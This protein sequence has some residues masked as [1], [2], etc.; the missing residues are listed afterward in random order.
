MSDNFDL[1]KPLLGDDYD[2]DFK[3]KHYVA[4]RAHL[5]PADIKE[6]KSVKINKLVH[7]LSALTDDNEFDKSIKFTPDTYWYLNIW[8]ENMD[9]SDSGDPLYV[10]DNTWSQ[11]D[12]KQLKRADPK[13]KQRIKGIL[14]QSHV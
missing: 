12:L 3:P 11:N 6:R 8:G 10:N 2:K 14:M 1:M 4:E 5:R 13:E 9:E 7:S